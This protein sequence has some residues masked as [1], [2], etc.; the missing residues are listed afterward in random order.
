MH[1][2]SSGQSGLIQRLPTF[3]CQPDALKSLTDSKRI[4]K[5]WELAFAANRT[6]NRTKKIGISELVLF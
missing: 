6:V 3:F 2:K 4:K 5:Q 1:L